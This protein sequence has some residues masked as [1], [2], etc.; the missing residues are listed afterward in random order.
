MTLK[1]DGPLVLAG[2]GNMGAAL[3]A[4]WLERG[5]DPSAV[6]IQDPSPPPASLALLERHGLRASARLDAAAAP[7]VIVVAVKPQIMDEVFPALARHAGPRTVVLS[8]AAGRTL[9]GFERHLEPSAAVVRAMPNTRLPSRAA[10]PWRWRTRT[11]AR[12]SANFAMP[13]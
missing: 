5:L 3:L 12:R 13:C 6:L 10:L 2:A 4:G 1:T 11:S 7:A 9:A 8:I